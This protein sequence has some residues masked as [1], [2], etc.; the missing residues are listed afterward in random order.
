MNTLETNG[1]GLLLNGNPIRKNNVRIR[2]TYTGIIMADRISAAPIL[3]NVPP[4]NL[5]NP[6]TEVAFDDLDEL[7]AYFNAWQATGD[8]NLNIYNYTIVA[9]PDEEDSSEQAAGSTI[10]DSRL[11]GKTA[12]FVCLLGMSYN[13][14][15]FTQTGSAVA[16]KAGTDISWAVTDPITT[17]SIIWE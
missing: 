13:A 7:K 9:D 11:A 5:I 3:N 10:T 4:S 16:M 1:E 14:D 12:R 6:D 15:Y 17:V 8:E 2:Y